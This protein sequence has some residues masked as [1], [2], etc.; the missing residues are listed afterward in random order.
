[1]GQPVLYRFAQTLVLNL[2]PV[3]GFA[4][5]MLQPELQIGHVRCH[6][7]WVEKSGCL[8][9]MADACEKW[10]C[11]VTSIILYSTVCQMRPGIS[12][13][14]YQDLNWR[15]IRPT[16]QYQKVTTVG[17]ILHRYNEWVSTTKIQKFP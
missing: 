16:V 5:A 2:G 15:L 12:R 11:K 13:E 1:M 17:T 10:Y 7:S 6:G 8:R 4:F 3:V 9:W 14:D